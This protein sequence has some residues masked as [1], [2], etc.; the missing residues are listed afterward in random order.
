MN[1]EGDA[2]FKADRVAMLA[3]THD[4]NF[5][6][7]KYNGKKITQ[8]DADPTDNNGKNGIWH[9]NGKVHTEGVEAKGTYSTRYTPKVTEDRKVGAL[10][11]FSCHPPNHMLKDCSSKAETKP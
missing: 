6:D 3:D 4:N 10:F 7:G 1:L 8:L 2:F 11:C 9:N 5:Q